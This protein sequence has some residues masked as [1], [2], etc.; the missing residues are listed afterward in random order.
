MKYLLNCRSFISL[1][2][3]FSFFGNFG[4]EGET[5]DAYDYMFKVVFVGDAGVGK[6]QIVKK[7][8]N[9][10]FD[11]DYTITIGVDF[12]TK[13]VEIDNKKIKLQ[14]WDPAGQEKYKGIT[15][16]C[17]SNSHLIVLVYAV[18]DKNTFEDIQNLV[19]DVKKQ[20]DGKTKFLLVGNKCDLDEEKQV[21][22]EEAQKYAGKNNMKFIEVSAKAGNGISDDMFNS[23]IL[24]L[25]DDMEK[26]EKKEKIQ[27]KNHDK[28]I[29]DINGIKSKK[30]S[31]WS[32]Y[33][34]CCPCMKKTKKNNK[35]QQEE[36]E[37]Q[38]ESEDEDY[39]KSEYQNQD[40][41]NNNPQKLEYSG[42]EE[43]EK[44]EEQ[45]EEEGEEPDVNEGEKPEKGEK[46]EENEGEESGEFDNEEEEE[47]F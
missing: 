34:S 43:S 23:I 3:L 29:E 45:E 11:N 22:T 40:E 16:G 21:S 7:F 12:A 14:L 19:K 25:L 32:E 10:S 44:V 46:P 42:N 35:K 47:S 8:V 15:E 30:D 20:T 28:D 5:K 1:M 41:N 24:E 33:C 18:N 26:E 17:Y 6:T 31:C 37:E 9:N 13:E 27:V 38:E 4:M 2:I 36:K 39:E